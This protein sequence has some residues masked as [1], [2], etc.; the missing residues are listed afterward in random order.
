MSRQE[1]LLPGGGRRGGIGSSGRIISNRRWRGSCN[2]THVWHWWNTYWHLW[3][4]AYR[5]LTVHIYFSKL[6]ELL[7]SISQHFWRLSKKEDQEEEKNKR[8]P[9]PKKNNCLYVLL[10]SELGLGQLTGCGEV[11]RFSCELLLLLFCLPVPPTIPHQR[12]LHPSSKYGRK[13]PVLSG[14]A[15]ILDN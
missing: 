7:D 13:S 14:Q 12:E 4:F 5:G 3:K 1:E 8:T 9:P 2:S 15:S 6:I 11:E 10:V